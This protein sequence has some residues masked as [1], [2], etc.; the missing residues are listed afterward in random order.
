MCLFL[1]EAPLTRQFPAPATLEVHQSFIIGGGEEPSA[2]GLF[3]FCSFFIKRQFE[4][5]LFS[6]SSGHQTSS[7]S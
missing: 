6:V 7:L 5:L 3:G 2:L 1:T 4:S